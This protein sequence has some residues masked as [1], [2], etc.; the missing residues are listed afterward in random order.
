MAGTDSICSI[1][2]RGARAASI[3]IRVKHRNCPHCFCFLS[4]IHT[5]DTTSL[6]L[7]TIRYFVS[8]NSHVELANAETLIII[9]FVM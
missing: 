4:M 5:R 3:F 7:K 1:Y 8:F 6:D 2:T 9:I